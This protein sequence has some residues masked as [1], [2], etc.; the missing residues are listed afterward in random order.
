[1]KPVARVE[2]MVLDPSL[3]GLNHFT[4]GQ[5]VEEPRSVEPKPFT[6]EVAVRICEAGHNEAPHCVDLLSVPIIR[7]VR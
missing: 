1:L 3:K 5:A 2:R 4:H 6:D 7:T